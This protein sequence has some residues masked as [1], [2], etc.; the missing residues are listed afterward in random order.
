MTRPPQSHTWTRASDLGLAA[1]TDSQLTSD[2]ATTH[3][4]AAG[5]VGDKQMAEIWGAATGS[6]V[7]II[8]YIVLTFAEL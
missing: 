8:H 6:G 7:E 4:H 2:P 1:Q 5:N 3:T